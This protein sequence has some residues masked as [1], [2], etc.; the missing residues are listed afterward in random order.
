[1]RCAWKE[2]LAILPEHMRQDVDRLSANTLMELR[3]RQNKP[4]ELVMPGGSR[5][6]EKPITGEDIR[7]VVNTSSRYSPWAAATSAFGY[8]TARGGHRIG[9]CGEVAVVNGQVKGLREVTSLCIRVAR[10]FPEIGDGVPLMGNILILGPPGSGKTT[11]LRSLCRRIAQREQVTVVDERGELF[12]DGFPTGRRMDVLRGCNKG[13][14]IDMALRTMGPSTIAVDEITAQEDTASLL[15]A[16]WCGVRLLA[17][18]HASG[19]QDLRSR[20]IYASLTEMKLFDTLLVMAA[21]KSW[22]VERMIY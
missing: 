11:M 22:H 13:Q 1:M 18:A 15:S 12:P 19:V 20:K 9:L 16:G 2:L 5:W 17:T 14:G 6:L 4:P 7:F 8:I 10:D 3:L 21:D